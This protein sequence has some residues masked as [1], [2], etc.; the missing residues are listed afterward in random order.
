M[1]KR[2]WPS[3]EERRYWQYVRLV[4]ALAG[5]GVDV[6]AKRSTSVQPPEP[7]LTRGRTSE[8]NPCESKSY[9]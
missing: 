9:P 6:E 2:P 7:K 1:S 5:K 4:Q 8:R 3:E